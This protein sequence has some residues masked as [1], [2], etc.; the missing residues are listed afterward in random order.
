MSED[1]V[2]RMCAPTLAGIKTGSLFMYETENAEDMKKDIRELNSRLKAKGLCLIP[3]KYRDK[4]ALLYMYRP[5]LLKTDLTDS[6]ARKILCRAGYGER[7]S[8][9]CV[10]MLAKR[11]KTGEGFPHEIGLFL[12]YPPEDVDGFI[13]NK[14][15]NFKCAG[16]WKVYGDET[17]AKRRFAAYTDC[18]RTYCELCKKGSDI[19]KLAVAI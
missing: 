3:L 15:M 10:A 5:K 8:E 7:T 17:K 13:A 1:T 9:Q 2:V 12:G 16:L 6:T 19:D 14:A 18:T 11:L 4:G